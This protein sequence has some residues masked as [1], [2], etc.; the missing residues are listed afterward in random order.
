MSQF[1]VENN[2]KLWIK[3]IKELWKKYRILRWGIN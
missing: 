3:K 2:I 1:E